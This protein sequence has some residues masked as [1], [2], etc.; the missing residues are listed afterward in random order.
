MKT[1]YSTVALSIVLLLLSFC[2]FPLQVEADLK[3]GLIAL[4]LFDKAKGKVIEDSS[5]NENHGE[6]N[7]GAKRDASKFGQA[8][9]TKPQQGVDIPITDRSKQPQRVNEPWGMVSY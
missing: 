1:F 6:L 8:V 2:V 5:G 7:N 4:W 3:D 9:V